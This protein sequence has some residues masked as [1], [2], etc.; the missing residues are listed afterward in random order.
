[1]LLRVIAGLVPNE[2]EGTRR[3]NLTP[4]HCECNEAILHESR[5]P[6]AYALAMTGGE[7]I[8]SP[9][10]PVIASVTEQSLS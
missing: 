5:S 6:L 3:N 2:S 4:R 1:M 9:P 7:V 8:T 10:P